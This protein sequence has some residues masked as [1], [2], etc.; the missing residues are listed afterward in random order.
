MHAFSRWLEET[1]L[2][3]AIQHAIW[4][5]EILQTVH[6]L[7][8][9]TVISS[10]AMVS[11]HIAGAVHDQSLRD[12]ARRHMPWFWGGL[13]LLAATGIVLIV[14]EPDRTLDDNPAFETKIVLIAVTIALALS[15]HLALKKNYRLWHGIDRKL[16]LRRAIAV[17]GMIV[18]CA[19]IVAGRWIAY[20]QTE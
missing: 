7:A 5:I 8:V 10:A 1:P 16:A 15:F 11:L 19:T 13:G 20:M 2:S 14:G 9:A 4:L 3:Q 17:L 6:I 12:T 18:I